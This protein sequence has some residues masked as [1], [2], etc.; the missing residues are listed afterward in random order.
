M[1]HVFHGDGEGVRVSQHGISQRIAHQ[2]HVDAGVLHEPRRGVV[3][4]GQHGDLFPGF[5][6]F[7]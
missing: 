6:H 2:D 4:A 7:H 1:N 5:L 3:V